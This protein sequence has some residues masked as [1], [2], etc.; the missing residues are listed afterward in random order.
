MFLVAAEAH[1]WPG[2][3]FFAFCTALALGSAWGLHRQIESGRIHR[4][5]EGQQRLAMW[6]ALVVGIAAFGLTAIA[7]GRAI[8]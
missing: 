6:M 3:G 4:A 5:G 1:P 2:I 8:F 7:L